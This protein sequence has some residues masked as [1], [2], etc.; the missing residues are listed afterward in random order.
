MTPCSA[1][2]RKVHAAYWAYDGSLKVPKG[3]KKVSRGNTFVIAAVIAELPFLRRPVALP[4]AARLWRR[5]ARPG[6]P[7]PAS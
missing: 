6:R 2:P 3:G 7:W 1:G 4:V 5:A